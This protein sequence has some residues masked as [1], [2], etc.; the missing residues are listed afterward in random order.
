MRPDQKI[1][2]FEEWERPAERLKGTTAILRQLASLAGKA[3][4]AA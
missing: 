3:S 4:K 1:V 2:F